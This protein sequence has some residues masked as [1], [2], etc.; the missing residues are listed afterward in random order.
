MGLWIDALVWLA[1]GALEGWLVSGLTSARLGEALMALVG[2]LGA[3]LG[4]L[5]LSLLAPALF[6]G[7]YF[8]PLSVL[9]ALAGGLAFLLIARFVTGH[10]RRERGG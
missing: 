6:T 5:A 2:V 10:D 4:G 7:L 9:A 3:L 1:L 8:T